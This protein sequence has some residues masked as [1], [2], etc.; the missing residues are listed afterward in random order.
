MT[1][2]LCRRLS[3]Y[4]FGFSFWEAATSSLVTLSTSF[5]IFELG[6]TSAQVAEVV[7]IVVVYSTS[8]GF[9]S[10][11]PSPHLLFFFP[12]KKV[13]QFFMISILVAVF[14]AGLS[15]RA[16]TRLGIRNT[17]LFALTLA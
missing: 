15:R 13:V 9:F 4:L 5:L 2:N 6:F 8:S 16:V 10:L 12:T 1:P 7:V 14:A 3:R 11:T 17:L